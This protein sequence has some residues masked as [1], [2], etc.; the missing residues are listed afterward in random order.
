MQENV[1]KKES[2]TFFHL[3]ASQGEIGYPI[4]GKMMRNKLREFLHCERWMKALLL[5]L[6]IFIQQNTASTRV[7]I[8]CFQNHKAQIL[9]KKTFSVSSLTFENMPS[10]N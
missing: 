7:F 10:L 1:S 8:D 2:K 5:P 6:C 3:R 4:C 9:K